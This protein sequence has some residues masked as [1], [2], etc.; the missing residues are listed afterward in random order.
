M[1]TATIEEL[2]YFIKE[3]NKGPIFF[4][5]AGA[6]RTGG[7]PLASEII[8]EILE[9]YKK[10]PRVKTLKEEEKTYSNLLVMVAKTPF[11]NTLEIWDVLI[12]TYIGSRIMMTN[13]VI[14]YAKNY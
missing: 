10:N 5:G 7:I 14:K 3:A 8:D 2:A 1:K 12:I 4:L 11:L 6:S 9:T 13:H